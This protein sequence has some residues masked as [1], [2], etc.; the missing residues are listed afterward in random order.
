MQMDL[1]SGAIQ[2]AAKRLHHC[3]EVVS[4][5]ALRGSLAGITGT[6]A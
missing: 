5:V 6:V 3:S 1:R 2:A 4:T